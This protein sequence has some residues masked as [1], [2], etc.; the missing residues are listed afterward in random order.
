MLYGSFEHTASVTL[1]SCAVAVETTEG[2]QV[3]EGICPCDVILQRD[4]Y[5]WTPFSHLFLQRETKDLYGKL[6]YLRNRFL[7]DNESSVRFTLPSQIIYLFIYHQYK[8]NIALPLFFN[9][10]KL[11]K[12]SLGTAL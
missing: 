3:T 9:M 5:R 4:R 1:E 12:N 10:T 7:F 11:R 2:K 6:L 8:A